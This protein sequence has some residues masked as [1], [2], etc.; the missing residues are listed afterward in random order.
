NGADTLHLDAGTTTFTMPNPVA[1]TS[2]Y[3]I[4]VQ[5]NPI[6][7]VCSVANGS[8][9]MG[10]GHINNV[11]VTCAPSTVTIGG[12]ITGLAANTGLV[13]LNNGADATPISPN[14]TTF[15]LHSG[16]ANG[17]TYDVTIGTQPYGIDFA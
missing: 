11:S 10:T 6:D 15:T 3:Q 7:Q 5:A 4:V 8:G 16:I 12:T 17:A 2:A 13:L 9:T 14:A 1:Y